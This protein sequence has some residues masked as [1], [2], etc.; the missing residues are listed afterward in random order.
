MPRPRTSEANPISDGLR[1][2]RQALGLT[3]QQLS[4]RLKVTVTTVARWETTR[5]P[6]ILRL[7]QIERLARMNNKDIL[8]GLFQSEIQQ[9]L[10][11]Q[12]A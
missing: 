9:Q 4:E 7:A 1:E 10:E 3:Q 2:L 12:H 11:N 8:A 5:P 6:R